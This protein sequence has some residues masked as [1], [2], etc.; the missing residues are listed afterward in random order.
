MFCSLYQEYT[1]AP[2][3]AEKCELLFALLVE[4]NKKTNL[5]R[6]SEKKDFQIKHII[7]SLLI[8][9]FFP[10]LSSENMDLADIGC[11]AGFPSLPL[12]M[13]CP[14]LKITAID[15][16]GKK[17][18][19]IKRA[20][21]ELGLSNIEVVTA[22]SRELNRREDWRGK[23]NIITARAVSDARTI[24]RET[25][26]LVASDGKIILYK[27][28][29]QAQSEIPDAIKA[30]SKAGLAWRM[31]EQCELPEDSGKRLFLYSESQC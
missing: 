3:F 12:A 9:R 5:T 20:A 13:A 17:T 23:F 6:I 30:S 10:E 15:S 18:S 27:T 11:G 8:I 22:R 26:N 16:I 24:F 19:F 7:D 2:D 28:P 1:S 29:E 4:E 25:K 31:T 14:N 21:Q